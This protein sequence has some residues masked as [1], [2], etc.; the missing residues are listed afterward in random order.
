L[1]LR[2]NSA[3]AMSSSDLCHWIMFNTSFSNK[4]QLKIFFFVLLGRTRF[5]A[6]LTLDRTRFG[7]NNGEC[8]HCSREQW[9]TTFCCFLRGGITWTVKHAS[10]VHVNSGTW[11]YYSREQW[12]H[13]PLF[14]PDRI[15]PK[16]KN[17]LNRVW[18]I[19]IKKLFFLFLIVFYSKKLVLNII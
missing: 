2:S 7:W 3:N 18:P 8:L 11:L 4:T 14:R 12:S 5:N 16:A 9:S 15:R 17:T 6:F 13:S 19:K 1:R 10:T